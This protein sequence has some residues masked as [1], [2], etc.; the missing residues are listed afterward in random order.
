MDTRPVAS[1]KCEL[2]RI[3]LMGSPAILMITDSYD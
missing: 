3:G 1:M 2:S